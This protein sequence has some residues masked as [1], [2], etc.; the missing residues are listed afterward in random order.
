MSAKFLLYSITMKMHSYLI[1][2][3]VFPQFG[4]PLHCRIAGPFNIIGSTRI[5]KNT[6]DNIAKIPNGRAAP[7]FTIHSFKKNGGMKERIFLKKLRTS[8]ASIAWFG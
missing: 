2:Q 7:L 5:G 6:T 3:V 8:A 4:F 1:H